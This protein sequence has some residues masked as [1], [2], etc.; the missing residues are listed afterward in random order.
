MTRP[1]KRII[2]FA[3]VVVVIAVLAW[4]TLAPRSVDPA[5]M[6]H[7]RQI[8]EACLTM[9]Q[10]SLTN[11]MDIA[12]DDP[13]IPEVIRA[14]E[15]SHIE[16]GGIDVVVMRSGL[17]SEYHLSRSSE[18]TNSWILCQ[19]GGGGVGGHHELLRIRSE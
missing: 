12:L 13:R 3:L 4:L 14:L 10:S 11:E 19:A 7:R 16:L 1:A 8:A 5:V 17:P 2:E 15:P 18:D 9:L 6:R